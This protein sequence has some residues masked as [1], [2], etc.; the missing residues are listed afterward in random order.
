MRP[1]TTPKAH[2]P[3]PVTRDSPATDFSAQVCFYLCKVA[4]RFIYIADRK[5]TAALLRCPRSKTLVELV[6]SI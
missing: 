6:V 3:A 1:A 2:S 5:A 4:D